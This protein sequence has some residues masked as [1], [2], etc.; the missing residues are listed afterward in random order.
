[1]FP[2]LRGRFVATATL[3]SDADVAEFE[4]SMPNVR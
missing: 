4:K 1:M 2:A 3:M